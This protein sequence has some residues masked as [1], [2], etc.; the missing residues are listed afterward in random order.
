MVPSTTSELHLWGESDVVVQELAPLGERWSLMLYL[1]LHQNH[2]WLDLGAG[3]F[4][5]SLIYILD[6][7]IKPVPCIMPKTLEFFFTQKSEE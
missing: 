3:R 7:A 4:L 2:V 5:L 6:Y 1:H